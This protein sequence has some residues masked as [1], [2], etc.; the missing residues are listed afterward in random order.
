MKDYV[1]VCIVSFVNDKFFMDINYLEESFGGLKLSLVLLLKFG[2]IVMFQ[3]D[4]RF[5]V[6]NL[7][8]VLDLVKKGC[9]DIYV[10]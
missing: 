6:D 7:D 1:S 5:Y 10:L 3:M 8:K 4:F 2:N 9:I